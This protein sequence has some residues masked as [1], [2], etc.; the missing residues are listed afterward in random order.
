VTHRSRD[1]RCR[2]IPGNGEYGVTDRHGMTTR[3]SA[4]VVEPKNS[5]GD[6]AGTTRRCRKAKGIEYSGSIA[7]ASLSS[8]AKVG[9]RL[10]IIL[11][12]KG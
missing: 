5:T 10:A 9:P 1:H 4:D 7:A 6:D 3:R 11:G 8:G 12:G 2:A